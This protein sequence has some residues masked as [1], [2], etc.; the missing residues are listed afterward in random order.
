MFGVAGAYTKGSPNDAHRQFVVTL[1]FSSREEPKKNNK[2]E[3]NRHAEPHGKCRKK[4]DFYSF[5]S[6]MRSLKRE[7][8]CY[9]WH[10]LR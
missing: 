3:P 2:Y 7:A 1:K 5:S 10:Y 8:R 4:H 9:F 6:S